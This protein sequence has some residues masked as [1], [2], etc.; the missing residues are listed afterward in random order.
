MGQQK[1]AVNKTDILFLDLFNENPPA[2]SPLEKIRY[3][4]KKWLVASQ[5]VPFYLQVWCASSPNGING[6]VRASKANEISLLRKEPVSEQPPGGRTDTHVDQTSEAQVQISVES[7]SR[8]GFAI[9]ASSSHWGQRF[10][11]HRVG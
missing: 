9:D 5:K 11:H 6:Q 4:F 1:Q 10:T 3:K 2:Q 7:F 8:L